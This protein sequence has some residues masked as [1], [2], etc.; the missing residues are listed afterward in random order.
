[1]SAL[2]T[3]FSKDVKDLVRDPRILIPFIISALILP[4]IGIIVSGGYQAAIAVIT[5]PIT[6]LAIVNLDNSTFT[7]Q[8]I[9]VLN[10]S[11]Y[12]RLYLYTS[13]KQALRE[14]PVD[15]IIVIPPGFGKQLSEYLE[16]KAPPPHI[17]VVQRV[18]SMGMGLKGARATMAASV[19]ESYLRGLLLEKLHINPQVF[20]AVLNPVSSVPLVYIQHKEVYIPA[21]TQNL[22]SLSLPL[23]IV[24]MIVAIIGITVLQMAATSMA[25]ENEVRTL[26]TLLTF[27][28]PRISILASKIMSSFAVG[29]GGSALNVIGFVLYIEI[30]SKGFS[31]ALSSQQTQ[32]YLALLRSLGITSV[33]NPV[34]LMIPTPSLAGV[35]I[36]SAIVSILFLAV[37]GV[38]IGS[39]C[40]DVRIASTFIGPISMPLT[41][42]IYFIAFIDPMQLAPGVRDALLSIPL[43]QTAVLS[44]MAIMGIWENYF[45]AGICISAALTAVLMFIASKMLNMEKLASIQYRLRQRGARGFLAGFKLIRVP[46][47]SKR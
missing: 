11:K 1:M 12:V 18:L 43:I 35:V 26:E 7:K 15:S 29:V 39:L 32:Q 37:I 24:P 2:S 34:K 41:I 3:L 9:E 46:R 6:S 31:Y 33:V 30:V 25:V 21:W 42:A 10:E 23:I 19:F 47:S 8:L 20:N 36:V 22:N 4:I 38:L 14:S 27:P 45:V 40:S 13:L 28:I 44:K 16:G 5:R 17:V